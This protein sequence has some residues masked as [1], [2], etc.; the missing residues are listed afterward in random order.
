MSEVRTQIKAQTNL[1]E[2]KFRAGSVSATIWKNESKT[3]EGNA[4]SYRTVSL[5]R[6]YR[7][8]IGRASCRER[9]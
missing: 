7:D 5:E 3:S 1:P 6:S 4:V 9:V 8:K 2:K